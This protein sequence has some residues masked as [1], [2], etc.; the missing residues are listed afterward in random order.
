MEP[1]QLERILKEVMESMKL[2]ESERFQAERC[3]KRIGNMILIRCNRED[4][5]KILEPVIA[6]WLRIYFVRNWILGETERYL[7]SPEGIP[8]LLTGMILP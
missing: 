4:I 7:L 6:R 1:E 8:P 3:V 2:G 5:P